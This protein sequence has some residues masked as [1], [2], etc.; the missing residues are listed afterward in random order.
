LLLTYRISSFSLSLSSGRWSPHWPTSSNSI[1]PSGIEINAFLEI[2]EDETDLEE[3]KRWTGFV[4]AVGGLFCAG[5]GQS[6]EKGME[7]SPEWDWKFDGDGDPLGTSHLPIVFEKPAVDKERVEHKFYHAL[8][9]R[10]SATCTES[11]TPFISLL[12][13]ASYAGLASLLNPHKLFDGDWT[14]IRVRYRRGEWRFE[15]GSV[16]DPVR[17]ERLRGG[18]GK[19][20]SFPF[21]L[22]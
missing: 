1:P 18:P 7:E 8:L 12:P 15:I 3:K 6:T 22:I 16:V 4:G 21:S 2:L 13:C 20:G 11:L 17:A 5:I 10:L 9:P 14:L 19:R